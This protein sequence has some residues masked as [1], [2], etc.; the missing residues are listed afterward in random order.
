MEKRWQSRRVR[1]YLAAGIWVEKVG[2]G[3]GINARPQVSVPK[4]TKL[5]LV[6]FLICI[7]GW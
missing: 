2:R 5:L 4:V 6:C 1:R 3:G 7:I